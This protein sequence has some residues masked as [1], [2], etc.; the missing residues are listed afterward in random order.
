[1][2]EREFSGQGLEYSGL[3]PEAVSVLNQEGIVYLGEQGERKSTVQRLASHFGIVERVITF[4]TAA[5]L[6]FAGCNLP[7]QSDAEGQINSTPSPTAPVP[8]EIERSPIPKPTYAQPAETPSPPVPVEHS[9]IPAFTPTATAEPTR[10]PTPIP[11]PEN[12][13]T[14]TPAATPTEV[15]TATP[16]ETPSEVDFGELTSEEKKEQVRH[17]IDAFMNAPDDVVYGIGEKKKHSYL[18]SEIGY[19]NGPVIWSLDGNNLYFIGSPDD[20]HQSFPSLGITDTPYQ[21]SEGNNHAFSYTLEGIYLGRTDHVL[22]TSIGDV[23]IPVGYFGMYAGDE[24]FVLPIA[25]GWVS[26]KEETSSLTGLIISESDRE[27]PPISLSGG[28]TTSIQEL[29][30]SLDDNVGS[31]MTQL[32]INSQQVPNSSLVDKAIQKGYPS[33]LFTLDYLNGRNEASKGLFNILEDIVL[34]QAQNSGYRFYNQGAPNGVSI[35]DDIAGSLSVEELIAQLPNIEAIM[36][37]NE[38]NLEKFKKIPRTFY[39]TISVT[40]ESVLEYEIK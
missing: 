27:N 3:N 21:A 20:M 6:I 34:K 29:L 5:S 31:N 13:A 17:N 33:E 15:P 24:R 36:N 14:V 32:N 2:I 23:V 38:F 37:D 12:A 4:A 19:V 9:P 28:P 35:T 7:G 16:T 11:P 1:M 10:T 22:K 25:F 39:E 8:I 40:T 30:E 18:Y 26:D